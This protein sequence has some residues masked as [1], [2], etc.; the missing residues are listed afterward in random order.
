MKT[1]KPCLLQMQSLNSIFSVIGHVSL[2]V[3]LVLLLDKRS[4]FIM[5]LNE[6]LHIFIFSFLNILK[7]SSSLVASVRG[8][9]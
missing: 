8:S 2:L 4:W 9:K 3:R 7:Y 6:N 1:F 5:A